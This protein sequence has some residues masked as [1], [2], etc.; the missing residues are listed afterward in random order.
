MLRNKFICKFSFLSGPYVFATGLVTFLESKEM[1]VLN[2][3]SYTSISVSI[4]SYLIVTNIGP[5]LASVLDREIDVKIQ[6]L[7]QLKIEFP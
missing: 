1:Y 6:S 7:Q 3:E 5:Y 4:V 2:H